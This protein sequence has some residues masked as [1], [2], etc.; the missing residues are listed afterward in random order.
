MSTV[1]DAVDD[2]PVSAETVTLRAT[3]L[4]ARPAVSVK[5]RFAETRY[6]VADAALFCTATS[7]DGVTATRILGWTT[8]GV[9]GVDEEDEPPPQAAARQQMATPRTRAAFVGGI[10]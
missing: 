7:G 3:I 10:I 5:A 6:L 9:V 2:Q 1:C 4:A 8:V